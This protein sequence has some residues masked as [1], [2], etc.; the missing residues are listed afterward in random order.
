MSLNAEVS[1]CMSGSSVGSRRVSSR[2]SAIARAACAAFAR[3]RTARREANTPSAMPRNVVVTAARASANRTLWSASRTSRKLS[4][5][6]YMALMRGSGIPT[7]SACPF[8]LSTIIV[9]AFCSR[10]TRCKSAGGIICGENSGLLPVHELL[11]KI[12]RCAVPP[13]SSASKISAEERMMSFCV[14]RAFVIAWFVSVDTRCST[15][16]E[17]VNEYVTEASTLESSSAPATKM[18]K[19]RLRKPILRGRN[20]CTELRM[21]LRVRVRRYLE[22]GLSEKMSVTIASDSQ[23]HELLPRVWG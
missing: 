23:A 15:R 7:T 10:C 20:L 5:S 16:F 6:K 14:R 13:W 21:S 17:R 19:I 22:S 8:R 18:S 1:A 3:G 2:P 11:M 9:A 12:R 4:Y